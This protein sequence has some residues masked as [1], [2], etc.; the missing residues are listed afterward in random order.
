[1]SNELLLLGERTLLGPTSG[2]ALT[3]RG[4]VASLLPGQGRR[5]PSRLRIAR[6]LAF[7]LALVIALATPVARARADDLTRYVDTF[8]G[9]AASAPNFG[10]GGGAG[11]TYPGAVAPFGM[12]QWSP[13]TLPGTVNFAGGYSYL[14]TQTRG[15]SLTHLSG[16]GCAAEQDFPF[17]PTT[18]PITS[19]PAKLGS[20]DIDSRYLASFSHAYEHA[21]PGYYQVELN[22]NGSNTIDSE[23]TATTR[24]GA[25]RFTYPARSAASMLINAGGSATADTAA[26]V[27]IDPLR[28]LITGSA[29]STHF[30]YQHNSY[31]VYFAAQFS[32]QFSQYGTWTKQ[33]LEPY[34][35]SSSDNAPAALNY[36]PFP[37]GPASLPGNPSGTS[38]S[39]AYVS[40]DTSTDPTVEVR[41]GVSYVSAAG[42]LDNLQAETGSASFDA[43]R[44]QADADWN[45]ALSHIDVHGGSDADRRTFYTALYHTLL[46]PTVFSDDNGRY[47]GMDG[48]LHTVAPGHVQY[49]NYSGWDIYRSEATLL[50]LLYPL[51]LSDMTQSLLTDQQQSG[52]LPKWP[53][54]NGQTNVMV[55]DPADLI[56]GDAW[57]FGA[58]GFDSSA[59]LQAMLKGATQSGV[60]T[61]AQ[62]IERPALSEYQLLGYVPHEEN[63]SSTE[64]TLSPVIPWGSASTT[65]EYATADYSIARFAVA[66]R[67]DTATYQSFM[68]RSDNWQKLYDPSV[69]YIEPRSATGAFLPG[70]G[71]T[72]A[73]DFAEGD[74]AQYTW[75]IPYNLAGLFARMGG[76]D[77]ARQ[78]LDGFLSQ[79]NSGP[80]ST[81]AFLGNEPTLETPWEYDWLGQPDKTQATVRRA[82]LTLYGPGPDG[83]PGNDD[84]GE[85]SSWY[86]FSALGLYP[87]IPAT[88]IFALGSPL[89][90]RT[91]IDLAGHMVTIN[92]QGASDAAPFVQHLTVNGHRYA[93]PWLSYSTLARGAKLGYR[94]S[95][96]A[97]PTWGASTKARPPSFAP[98]ATAPACSSATPTQ[99]SHHKLSASLFGLRRG[100]PGLRFTLVAGKAKLSRLTIVLPRGLNFRGRR[101]HRRLVVKG[102][103]VRGPKLKSTSL[104]KGKLTLTLHRPVSRVLVTI[105]SRGLKE[106]GGLRSKARHHRIRYLKLTVSVTDSAHRMT[107][108]TQAVRPSS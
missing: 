51:R 80:N 68:A 69:G 106:S 101:A 99:T 35:T 81:T 42:A 65:L 8:S 45:A 12:L 43:L 55:G 31:S 92:A 25:A 44:T 47:V 41:V 77:I 73:D 103:T 66:A 5:R 9:T 17:L 20:S 6:P 24:A 21:S 1:M 18:A 102:V 91:T 82:L 14:D 89:F 67:C 48:Q 63:G 87:E 100:R 37:G 49:T 75:M 93:K 40:F 95:A 108:L 94:L 74:A 32:R 88:P 61:T 86:V 83:Y 29:T 19:S 70:A 7:A 15:F 26:S 33:L 23:L 46:A 50:A 53:T 39:G 11:N 90:P 85:L 98:G 28:Q 36:T 54:A 105:S 2:L 78:R 59:A 64:A 30:C 13:D 62:Y 4:E 3:P 34:S 58:R 96:T 16:A 79:L 38:Q 52:W 71:A 60:S 107:T 27:Q 56:I 22:P 76:R 57:A 97:R 84:L 10:T 72:S 104:R